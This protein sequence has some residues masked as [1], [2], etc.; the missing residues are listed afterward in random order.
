MGL[1]EQFIAELTHESGTTRRVIERVPDD[2]RTWKPHEKSMSLGELALHIAGLP[3]GIA[4]LL[5]NLVAEVPIVPLRDDVPVAEILVTLEE[6]V[7]FATERLRA[8]GDEG[9][10]ERWRMTRGGQTLLEM[11]RSDMVRSVMLNHAYHHRGQLSVYL[12]L[13]DVPLPSIYGPSADEK[14]F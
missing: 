3:R 14:V 12:R 5:E 8:W 7:A 6:S 13:L 10:A 9:L 11:R 1:A 4:G 2:R